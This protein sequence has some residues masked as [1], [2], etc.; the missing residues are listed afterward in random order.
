M[1]D[2]Y[3]ADTVRLFVMFAAPPDQH[4]EWSESGVEGGWRFL[5]RVWSGVYSCVQAGNPGE[6]DVTSLEPKQ[7]ALRREVHKTIAKVSDDIG[8]RNTFNTAIAAVMELSN[9]LNRFEDYSEQGRAVLREGWQAVVQL[10]APVTPHICE[11]LWSELGHAEGLHASSWPLVDESALVQERVMIVVQV[12]GKVRGRIEVPAD[13][14]EDQ[15]QDIAVSTEN[16]NRFLEGTTIR[17]VIYI[18]G[19]LLNIVAA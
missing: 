16:V 2:R 6:A 4:V 8:R 9:H 14:S 10:L 7:Q 17:K 12:N 15:V 19:K 1:I 13:A 11:H 18:P 3:G 5:K